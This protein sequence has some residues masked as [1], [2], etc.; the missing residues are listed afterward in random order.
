MADKQSFSG[1]CPHL[2]R[3]YVIAVWYRTV[4][5]A[6]GERHMEKEDFECNMGYKSGCAMINACPVYNEAAYTE[7]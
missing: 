6:N 1:F 2:K 7:K 3:K 5:R 4:T